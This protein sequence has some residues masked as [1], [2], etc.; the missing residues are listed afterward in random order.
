MTY[1]V[2]KAFLRDI[3]LKFTL[4]IKVCVMKY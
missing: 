1:A 3:T 4:N 2:G